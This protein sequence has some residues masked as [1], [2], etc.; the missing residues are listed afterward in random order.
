[1]AFS[2]C[3]ERGSA[4]SLLSGR[5][6]LSAGRFTVANMTCFKTKHVS[7]FSSVDVVKFGCCVLRESPTVFADGGPANESPLGE[8]FSYCDFSSCDHRLSLGYQDSSG[9]MKSQQS[10]AGWLECFANSFFASRLRNTKRQ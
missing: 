4:K 6:M 1:M 5:M 3:D 8:N 7:F 2:L 9:G 10:Y